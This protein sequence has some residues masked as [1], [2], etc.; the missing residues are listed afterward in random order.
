MAASSEGEDAKSID[1]AWGKIVKDVG[2]ISET[3]RSG[4]IVSRPFHPNRDN[5]I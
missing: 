3:N 5:A 4:I 1:E 2:G